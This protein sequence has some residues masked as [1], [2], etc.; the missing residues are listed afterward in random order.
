MSL[1]DNLLVFLA[2]RF[3]ASGGYYSLISFLNI[4]NWQSAL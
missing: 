3:V 4:L 2:L 1:K